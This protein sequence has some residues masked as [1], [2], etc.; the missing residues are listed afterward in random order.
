M[1]AQTG[2]IG[3]KLDMHSIH[4][5]KL[6]DYFLQKS[7]FFEI[8]KCRQFQ[9]D[10]VTPDHSLYIYI[11]IYIYGGADVLLRST[12]RP[13]IQNL[14]DNFVKKLVSEIRKR[15]QLHTQRDLKSWS[16]YYPMTIIC[17]CRSA[18]RACTFDM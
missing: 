2:S 3:H 1:M 12:Y 15:R 10:F 4:F 7:L 6:C 14:C 18:P 13:N 11:Y 5:L 9:R 16:L 17:W 8:R